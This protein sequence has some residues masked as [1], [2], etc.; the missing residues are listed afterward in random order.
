MDKGQRKRKVEWDSVEGS[1]KRKKVRDIS[2]EN[3]VSMKE[4]R[5]MLTIMN[6]Y[7]FN[8]SLL[9]SLFRTKSIIKRKIEEPER[10][11][12]KTK[13]RANNQS[14]SLKVHQGTGIENHWEIGSQSLRI[15]VLKFKKSA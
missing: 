2:S 9:K 8:K 5:S 4:A 11:F 3:T 15:K 14:K 7:N 6:L 12:W 10:G 13:I 1:M